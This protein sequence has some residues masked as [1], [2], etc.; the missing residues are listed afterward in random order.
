MASKF[1]QYSIAQLLR[2]VPFQLVYKALTYKEKFFVKHFPAKWKSYYPQKS[3]DYTR[4]NEFYSRCNGVV[5]EICTE[6]NT[7][8]EGKINIFNKIV[9][10]N[11]KTDWLKD[12]L[13]Q[14]SWSP[15]AFCML[16][17]VVQEGC[18]DVKYVL[19]VNKMNHIV[20]VALAY[21]HTK[22]EK[23]IDYIDKAIKSWMEQVA[24]GRSVANRIVMDL[25]FRIINLIQTILLCHKSESFNKRTLPNILGIIREHVERIHRFSTPRWF[26]TGNGMNHITGE[27]VGLILGQ[28]CLN[29]F[30]IK[31][32]KRYYK[33]EHKYLVEVLDRTIAPSGTYLE[34]SGNY[35]R[36]VAEF[37]VCFDL[38]RKAFSNTYI[39]KPYEKG[40]YTKRLL[41]YLSAINYH[42]YLPNIGDNDDARVL[43]SFLNKKQNVGYVFENETQNYNNDNY[44]DG[45]QWLYRSKDKNDVYIHTRIGKFTNVNELSG[46]HVHNDILSLN[47]GLKGETVFIDKGCLFYN[48]GIEIIKKDRSISSHN[49]VSINSIELNNIY[50]N[51]YSDYPTSE[52]VIDI[53]EDDKCEF[54]GVLNYRGITHTRTIEYNTETIVIKDNIVVS[55]PNGQAA[56]IR[57]MLHPNIVIEKTGNDIILKNIKGVNLAKMNI[58]GICEINVFEEEF[59]PSYANRRQTNVIEG[60]FKLDKST[61][62]IITTIQL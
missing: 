29:D 17:P 51:F 36:V 46:T 49:T 20:R 12:P 41:G 26:K 54:C 10:F 5:D 55:S 6:A 14:C 22:E 3:I 50:K 32:Y 27:M 60:Y 16:A 13:S 28:Q 57:Y 21:Y 7:I 31:S 24:P 19:E 42:D 45:S 59:A 38:L 43:I 1:K 18:N 52:C 8:L 2:I 39:Y 48:S 47:L 40:E 34:Q 11:H 53:K 4:F 35:T 30:G 62:N 23:Y 58:N 25:A 44:L 56:K 33:T 15:D 37:L 61:Y 9:E